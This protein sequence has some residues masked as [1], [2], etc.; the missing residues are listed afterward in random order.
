MELLL[1][2]SFQRSFESSGEKLLRS[3]IRS[4]NFSQ[5]VFASKCLFFRV[6]HFV[7]VGLHVLVSV[8][9]Q[10]RL[11]TGWGIVRGGPQESV[12]DGLLAQ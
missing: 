6:S 1:M 11:P 12:L 8:S 2:L 3:E 10:I 5:N 9:Y 7:N 4:S